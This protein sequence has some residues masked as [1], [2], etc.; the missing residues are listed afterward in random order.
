[1]DESIDEDHLDDFQFPDVT[2]FGS[3][4]YESVRKPLDTFRFLHEADDYS[5]EVNTRKFFI[6]VFS[7][8]SRML[9]ILPVICSSK[10]LSFDII[11]CLVFFS[12]IFS[13]LSIFSLFHLKTASS[14]PF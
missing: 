12:F 10:F 9:L 5:S 8:L 4:Q 3:V 14:F 7:F 2:N 1:M 11:V 6:R 13:F